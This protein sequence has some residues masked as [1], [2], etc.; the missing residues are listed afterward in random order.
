LFFSFDGQGN[1]RLV[2]DPAAVVTDAYAYHAFG[3]EETAIGSDPNPFRF[4]GEVGYYRDAEDRLYVRA[5]YYR[6]DLGV[7]LSRDPVPG[8]P[9]YLY[10]RNAPLTLIDPD[11]SQP[12]ASVTAAPQAAAPMAP[13]LVTTPGA[14]SPS[15][16]GPVTSV[17]GF[18]M[19][20]GFPVTAFPGRA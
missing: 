3:N 16:P 8:E 5:R 10:V 2:A 18:G 13:G 14:Q 7:W 20:S 15:S 19:R 4:G 6:P 12:W 17:G 11:G 9:S 1:I